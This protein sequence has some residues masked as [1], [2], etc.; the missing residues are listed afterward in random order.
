M[1]MMSKE[2]W[3]LLLLLAQDTGKQ[4]YKLMSCWLKA[5][6]NSSTKK[7]APASL[8]ATSYFNPTLYG[9]FLLP[10]ANSNLKGTMSALS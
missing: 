9:G 6:P 2:E 8:E 1:V 7:S 3:L 5:S 10:I 4:R